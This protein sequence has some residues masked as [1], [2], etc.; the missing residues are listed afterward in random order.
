MKDINLIPQKYFQQ[1]INKKK[2]RT[3]AITIG[4]VVVFLLAGSAGLFKLRQDLQK[5]KN[6]WDRRTKHTAAYSEAGQDFDS[7][8]SA[9]KKRQDTAVSLR[10]Q[11]ID[12]PA[13]MKHIE[14][15]A[16]REL[17]I[18]SLNVSEGKDG[19]LLVIINGFVAS[20]QDTNLFVYRLEKDTYFD[21]VKVTS[22]KRVEAAETNN[23]I[24]NFILSL[25]INTWK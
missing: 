20:E 6:G 5:T 12:V 16:P 7:I 2:K 19:Q 4:L 8:K 3:R 11:G 23:H 14:Q 17:F 24:F 9:V 25:T 15:C 18:S 10:T 21:S 22:A 1:Q 13:L